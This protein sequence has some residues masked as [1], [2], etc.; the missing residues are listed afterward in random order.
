MANDLQKFSAGSLD[1][2]VDTF[3]PDLTPIVSLTPDTSNFTSGINQGVGVRYGITPIPG[4]SDTETPTGTRCNGI[5]KSEGSSGAGLINR[6]RAFKLSLFKLQSF[7]DFNVFKNYIFLLLA[8]TSNYLDASIQSLNQSTYFSYDPLLSDGFAVSSWIGESP[9]SGF[10]KSELFVSGVPTEAKFQEILSHDSAKKFLSSA[11]ITASNKNIPTQWI[12]GRTV[13]AGDATHAPAIN[14]W[15]GESSVPASPVGISNQWYGG[16]PSCIL[17]ANYNSS[18]HGINAY[19]IVGATGKFNIQYGYNV[20]LATIAVQQPSNAPGYSISQ[21]A[22]NFLATTGTKTTTGTSYGAADN[23]SCLVNDPDMFTDCGYSAQLVCGDNPFAIIYQEYVRQNNGVINQFVNLTDEVLKPKPVPVGA[24]NWDGETYKENGYEKSTAFALWPS[25]ID[26]TPLPTEDDG[27]A[28]PFTTKIDN[29]G[30]LQSGRSYELTYSYYNKRLNFETNVG[31]PVKIFVGSSVDAT[32]VDNVALGLADNNQADD[33]ETMYS[34]FLDA[35]AGTSGPPFGLWPIF[36]AGGDA[37]GYDQRKYINYLEVRFYYR[38]IGTFEWLP[39]GAFDLAEYWFRPNPKSFLRICAGA[40]AGLP[41]GQPGGF[42]DYSQLPKQKYNSVLVFQNRVFWFSNK[43]VNF[44]YRDNIFAYAL[45]NTVTVQ[46]GEFYGG[47]VHNYPGEAEQTS[48]LMMFASNAIY[49]GRFTG[50]PATTAVQVSPDSVGEYPLD[51]SDFTVDLWTTITSFSHRSACVAQGYL[52]YWGPQGIFRDNGTENP[53]RISIPIEP[54]LFSA[55]DHSQ[56]DQ[57]FCYYNNQTQE[58]IWFYPPASDP[59]RTYAIVYNV[60]D[61]AFLFQKF[62][63]KIDDA[64]QVALTGDNSSTFGQERTV[65]STRINNSESTQRMFFFDYLNRS[66]DMT[67]TSEMMCKSVSTP[68]TGQRRFTLA[69]GSNDLLT[70]SIGDPICLQQL[71]K[72]WTATTGEDL[73]GTVVAV[74]A[75]PGGYLDVKL[76]DSVT[77]DASASLD[78][79]QYFPI[80]TKELHGIE[81]NFESKYWLPSGINNFWRF[82]YFYLLFKYTP[83]PKTQNNF[84]DIAYRTPSGADFIGDSLRFVDNSDGNYQLYYP[85]KEGQLNNQGQAIKLKLSGVHI[86]EE[87]VLQYLETHALEESGNVLKMYMPTRS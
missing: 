77:F 21:V 82:L 23:R 56:A 67:T 20:K 33:T 86:G 65:I 62:H 51:G 50:I 76:P 75:G 55:Y 61:Q 27:S 1:I 37:L 11:N 24:L 10:L 80:M 26:N 74:N 3:N 13:T 54:F 49:V 4:Q 34:Q 16:V 28:G 5:M 44:S 30:L 70:I 85:L 63:C 48:R 66:G 42:N 72:Y 15:Y 9:F 43:T 31:V 41:G 39:A 59:T 40:I 36:L 79:T 84:F 87:W 78:F 17:K 2:G 47:I 83:L 73:I 25:Y 29:S 64:V 58:I 35:T 7:T 53:D 12:I 19:T 6:L 68:A 14:L 60:L 45:R 22:L 32:A 57:I 18:V 81:Y 69:S 38:E 8:D 46:T 52:Y 71:D